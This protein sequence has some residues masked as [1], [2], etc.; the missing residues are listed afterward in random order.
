MKRLF[1][2][3][4]FFAMTARLDGAALIIFTK[5]RP[6]QCEALLESLRLVTGL[7]GV[8]ALCATSNDKFDEGYRLVQK[9]YP[10]V[11]FIK[12][13]RT[14]NRRDFMPLL[15]NI[16]EHITAQYIMFAVDDMIVINE[17]DIPLCI[18]LME[19]THAYG[20][21]LRLGQDIDYC[22]AYKAPMPIPELRDVSSGFYT[23]HLTSGSK[24]WGYPHTVDM[25][26]Y[27]RATLQNALKLAV[28]S[29]NTFEAW[30]A[31]QGI[32]QDARGMCYE[33]SHVINIPLNLV[34]QDY[35]NNCSNRYSTEQLLKLFFEGWRIDVEKLYKLPH[36]A[37]HVDI[38]IPLRKE[39]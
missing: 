15:R 38:D 35:A 27:P 34:Q 25:T 26:I 32:P 39:N 14:L 4:F 8:Y 17:V 31:N 18:A 20:C 33:F 21:Y 10:T 28:M 16:F 12:Q 36:N 5:D 23:W 1:A 24:C 29:P 19:Q 2:S 30:W 22:Y 37:P 7:T 3:L 11:R 9:K 13:D 6:M